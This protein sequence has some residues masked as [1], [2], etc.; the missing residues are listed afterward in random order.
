MGDIVAN[1]S[2]GMTRCEQTGDVDTTNIEV[3]SMSHLPGHPIYPVISSND[4]ETRH[5]GHHLFVTSRMVP[6][7][8]GGQNCGQFH[9]LLL[10]R[11]DDTIRINRIDNSRLLGVLIH[12]EVHVVVR[13]SRQ[14]PHSHGWGCH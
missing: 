7:M 8:V 10:H 14:Y 6:M 13:Q 2:S 11:L 12:Q 9:S 5:L 3:I 1:M 4:N